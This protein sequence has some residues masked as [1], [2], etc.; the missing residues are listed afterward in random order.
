MNYRI[1]WDMTTFAVNNHKFNIVEYIQ[2]LRKAEFTQLQAETIA[3]ETEL[4]IES[5][6]D[7][8]KNTIDSKEL[9]TKGDIGLIKRDVELIKRDIELIKRDIE[10][11]KLEIE[12]KLI[13][14]MI[15]TVTAGVVAMAGILKIMLH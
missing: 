13:K 3:Q 4:L 1:G 15:G 5:V 11:A 7:Q 2:K 8:T 12:T 10:Q 14:W 9:S 6:I